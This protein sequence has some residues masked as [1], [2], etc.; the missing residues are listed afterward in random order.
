MINIYKY[1]LC[2]FESDSPGI[3]ESVPQCSALE[4]ECKQLEKKC[5]KHKLLLV[6]DNILF[7]RSFNQMGS[8][9]KAPIE[10]VMV[11]DSCCLLREHGDWG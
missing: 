5:A 6:W 4:K 7:E 11:L 3:G 2:Q 8:C 1:N 9:V 10:L